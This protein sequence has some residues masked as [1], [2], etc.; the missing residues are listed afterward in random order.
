MSN[1][2]FATPKEDKDYKNKTKQK[3]NT[4]LGKQNLYTV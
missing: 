3:W 1:K 4:T 2:N